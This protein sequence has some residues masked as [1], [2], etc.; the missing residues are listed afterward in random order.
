MDRIGRNRVPWVLAASCMLLVPSV[1]LAQTYTQSDK[2]MMA[3]RSSRFAAAK[4]FHD[5]N[6]TA[7]EIAVILP[8]LMD[9]RDSERAMVCRVDELESDVLVR[10]ASY[11]PKVSYETQLEVC[12]T[13]FH[14]HRDRIWAT[15]SKRCGSTKCDSLRALVEPTEHRETIEVSDG[16]KRIDKII[17]EWDVIIQQRNARL[18]AS[19]TPENGT[20]V[21]STT[22]ITT[23][24]PP[25]QTD[26][27][28]Y[29]TSAPLTYAE[30]VGMCKERFVR[31]VGGPDV[32]AFYLY[33]DDDLNEVDVADLWATRM[34]VWW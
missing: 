1:A 21:A 4:T 3:Y 33:R 23:P 5:C 29:Y 7:H 16:I 20:V 15:I 17:A 10:P 32:A 34:H 2:D 13:N 24:A 9:L 28:V 27:I 14:N 25:A 12:R 19:A 30:L 11:Q 6:L 18:N 8:L 22:I 31:R 26:T